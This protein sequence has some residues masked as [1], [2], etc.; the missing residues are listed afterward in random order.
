MIPPSKEPATSSRR[1]PQMILCPR[2]KRQRKYY[3]KGF[4]RC[5]WNANR[6]A[7]RRGFDSPPRLKQCR[8]AKPCSVCGKPIPKPVNHFCSE[9]CRRQGE[10]SVVVSRIERVIRETGEKLLRQLP[11]PLA[12]ILRRRCAGDTLMRIGEALR[13]TRERV[14]QLEQSAV[15]HLRLLKDPSLA[16][17]VCRGC[18]CIFL[19]NSHAKKFCSQR[20]YKIKH[21]EKC[22]TTKKF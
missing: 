12:F 9:K 8:P 5:C 18:R 21:R 14:R 2:C 1:S 4:C 16:A 13:C 3:A 11:A 10:R 22:R 17:R 20:F 6:I 19:A 15:D 7:L